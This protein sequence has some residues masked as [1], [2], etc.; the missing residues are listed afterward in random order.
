MTGMKANTIKLVLNKKIESWLSHIDDEEVRALAK[1]DTLVTGGAIA[2]MLM[3]EVPN[4]YD[5]YF[6]TKETAFAVAS[7]YTK[8]FKEAQQAKKPND[9]N[10]LPVVKVIKRKNCKGILEERVVVWMQ[11]AGVAGEAD[12]EYKY[13]EMRPEVE[14]DEF[15]SSLNQNEEFADTLLKDPLGTAESAQIKLSDK[16]NYRPVFF[17]E[18]AVTLSNKVQ[19]VI[20]F[21]GEPA[22]IHD[23]YD[24]VHCMCWYDHDKGRLELPPAALESIL[25]KSLVY[26][27]SLY[28]VAS[29]FRLRK[30]LARGFR[31]TA[32]QLLKIM[33]QIS[34]L[35]LKDSEVLKEQ[36]IG[37]DQAYMRQLIDALKNAPDKVDSTY[38]SKVVD[39]IFD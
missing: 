10:Y 30:F 33:W 31:I 13:F 25:S 6:K 1:R 3:G 35:N 27:G 26:N 14:A 39:E 9:I 20:R 12:T 38:L 8:T 21:F 23:S 28:P 19:I 7:Y 36:L 18:N 11:S 2:S 4:D 15:V 22:E 37:V 34:E 5:I 29:I 32:G 24:Y 16:P 17:S